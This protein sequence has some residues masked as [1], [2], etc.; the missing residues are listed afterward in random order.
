MKKVYYAHPMYLYGKPQEKRD[1]Q[2][3]E[4]LGFDIIN[5][6]ADDYQEKFLEWNRDNKPDDPMDFFYDSIDECEIVAFRA[7]PDLR[8]SA[9]TWGEV[10]Y[11]KR[12]GKLIIELPVLLSARGLSIDDTRELLKLLGQR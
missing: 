12:C 10:N 6:G 9:G 11:A 1:V 2:L 8:V 4:D 5:P 7:N 3:L